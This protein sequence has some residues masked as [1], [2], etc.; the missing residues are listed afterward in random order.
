VS[1]SI[2]ERARRIHNRVFGGDNPSRG[3]ASLLGVSDGFV[4]LGLSHVEDGWVDAG[5][6]VVGWVLFGV[7]V[8]VGSDWVLFDRWG[9]AWAVRSSRWAV[10]LPF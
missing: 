4:A 7:L 10:T 1:A 9:I 5:A 8:A 3:T 6:L 2:T